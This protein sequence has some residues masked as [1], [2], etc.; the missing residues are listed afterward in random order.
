[1]FVQNIAGNICAHAYYV[2]A[3]GD[4][5]FKKFKPKSFYSRREAEIYMQEVC[6]KNKLDPQAFECSECDK[7][8]KKYTDHAGHR[9]YINRI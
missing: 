3:T 8:E 1:M 5:N 2:Y 6:Y 9:F 7:H 4:F